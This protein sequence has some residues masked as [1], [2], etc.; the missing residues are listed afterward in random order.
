MKPI[1]GALVL[2]ASTLSACSLS[3]GTVGAWSD[4]QPPPLSLEGTNPVVMPDGEVV[5]FGGIDSHG[6]LNRV[7]RFD[8]KD[9]RWSQGAQ[10][11]VQQTGSAIAALSNGSVLVAGGQGTGGGSRLVATTWLYRPQ[12]DTWTRVGDLH[13]ARWG[14]TAV[15]LTNGRVLVAGGSVPLASPIQLPD[16][17][18]A[19]Y[20]FNN[21]AETFDPETNSWSLVGPMHVARGFMALL[22]L[23]RGMALA[24]GG[25]AAAD[26]GFVPV[27]ALSSTEV[28]DPTTGAWTVST[29]L[30]EPL[31][32]ASGVL[33]PDGRALV[34]G[35]SVSNLQRGSLTNAVLYD[36]LK[37]AWTA[38]GSTVPGASAPI[39]LGDGR[40]FVAAVQAGQIQG[41]VASWVVGGQVFDPASG[42]WRFATST[43]L[44]VPS[45]LRQ[46]DAPTVF[47]QATG[48]AVVLIETAG[49]ALSFDP[50]GS[51]PAVLILDST[52]LALV[53]AGLA[54]ALCLSLVI[55][56]VRVRIRQGA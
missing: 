41:D 31:C 36:E 56:Y 32:G 53:L 42:D 27:G 2:M 4:E 38:A 22:A 37:H 55:Q 9:N 3:F 15:R 10:M 8:P 30:P 51:P 21:S 24:V 35:R 34:I 49:L 6:F 40:V 12:L 5:F 54:V 29:P 11:P 25:C 17:S 19:F 44:L 47:A 20:E 23:P 16:G 26:E 43:S 46:V 50:A 1:A 13:V 45:R 52:G 33:L 18:I 14:A 7:L 39:L 28:F 48:R